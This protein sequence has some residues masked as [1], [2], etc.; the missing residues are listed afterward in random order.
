M[1]KFADKHWTEL[2]FSEGDWV[3]VKLKPYRQ[4]SVHF[5]V[6]ESLLSARPPDLAAPK[7]EYRAEAKY[8]C[9]EARNT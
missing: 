4:N 7:K 3:F 2:E 1:K 5:V 9:L 8:M 6:E